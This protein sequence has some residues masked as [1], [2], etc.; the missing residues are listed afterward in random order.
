[1]Y[2]CHN[3][4]NMLHRLVWRFF[5]CSLSHIS[6]APQAYMLLFI[7]NIHV[8]ATCK[9]YMVSIG[10]NM[11]SR[12]NCMFCMGVTCGPNVCFHVA[13]M[14]CQSVKYIYRLITLRPCE[15]HVNEMRIPFVHM[16]PTCDPHVKHT[17]ITG[18]FLN[19]GR[20]F[21]EFIFLV[22][23]GLRVALGIHSNRIQN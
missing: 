7:T 15:R 1:M 19:I 3:W 5:L 23:F 12:I 16:W 11:W 18:L 8:S 6:Y 21:P 2:E 9:M 20:L 4:R 10:N 22:V 14:C 13:S 17:W